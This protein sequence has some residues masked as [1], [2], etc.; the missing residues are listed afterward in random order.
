MIKTRC[1]FSTGA[2][3][4]GVNEGQ[5]RVA[6]TEVRGAVLRAGMNARRAA[7]VGVLKL[8]SVLQ[9]ALRIG[10]NKARLGATYQRDACCCCVRSAQA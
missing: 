7:R 5:G 9:R 4:T 3:R 8:L 10:L 6:P 1:V 2:R